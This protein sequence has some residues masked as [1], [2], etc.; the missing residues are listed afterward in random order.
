MTDEL[1]R[2]A[3]LEERMDRVDSWCRERD[4]LDMRVSLVEKTLVAYNGS[5]SK[6]EGCFE[7][8]HDTV[9]GWKANLGLIKWAVGAVGI[10]GIINMVVNLLHL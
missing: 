4:D 2:L 8:L 1:S 5:I 7:T 6:I 10:I 9:V 3:R